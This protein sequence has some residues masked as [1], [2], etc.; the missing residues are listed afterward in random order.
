MHSGDLPLERIASLFSD[1]ESSAAIR[2]SD[3]REV[4]AD[5]AY[6]DRGITL[7]EHDCIDV[8]QTNLISGV[9]SHAPLSGAGSMDFK[10]LLQSSRQRLLSKP[11]PD[12][13]IMESK[14]IRN[15]RPSSSHSK[16]K[17]T[18]G[19]GGLRLDSESN[20]IINKSQCCSPPLELSMSLDPLCISPPKSFPA[21]HQQSTFLSPRP[22]EHLNRGKPHNAVITTTARQSQP[23]PPL[24]TL[25]EVQILSRRSDVLM[26]PKPRRRPADSTQISTPRPVSTILQPPFRPAGA[27]INENSLFGRHGEGSSSLLS[28][29]VKLARHHS[30]RMA[31]SDS[32]T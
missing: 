7:A 4:V 24:Y 21:S 8:V 32:N 16:F 18:V 2:R 15:I 31:S 10:K 22:T 5:W 19:A 13:P 27:D 1:L 26:S 17:G 23:E 11:N 29:R 9:D 14:P 3:G 28:T 6:A 20:K 30:A 25:A 12:M